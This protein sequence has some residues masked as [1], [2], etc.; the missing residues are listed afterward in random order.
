[1]KSPCSPVEDRF[2]HKGVIERLIKDEGMSA[3]E[4][5]EAFD[6]LV[7]FL[8]LCGT[9]DVPLA[10]TK[11]IDV[12]WHNF[13]LFT[14]DYMEFCARYYGKYLHHS[15]DWAEHK[16]APNAATAT[17][18]LMRER[19]GIQLIGDSVECDGINCSCDKG[20]TSQEPPHVQDML[21]RE[22]PL[23]FTA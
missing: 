6:H 16:T 23:A 1:M 17:K 14:R 2:T 10:P 8:H 11:T 3:L 13:I 12:A 5:G 15:P 4:A 22:V 9:T 20:I 18:R 19:F 7:K 21:H